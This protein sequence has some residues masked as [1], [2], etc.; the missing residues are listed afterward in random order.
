MSFFEELW[1][2]AF[3]LLCR[4][5]CRSSIFWSFFK[6]LCRSQKG[7]PTTHMSFDYIDSF[8]RL[9]G[10]PTEFSFHFKMSLHGCLIVVLSNLLYFTRKTPSIKVALGLLIDCFVI[11]KSWMP[12]LSSSS[13]NNVACRLL[14]PCFIW[15][16]TFL[17][18]FHRLQV[19]DNKTSKT[20]CS[21]S[22]AL[23]FPDSPGILSHLNWSP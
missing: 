12:E 16:Q 4:Y 23:G 1:S 18:Q 3:D 8:F 9:S 21:V 19:K 10:A 20:F 11:N 14:L 22:H 6:K 5:A 15:V 17:N 2:I 13:L 7:R